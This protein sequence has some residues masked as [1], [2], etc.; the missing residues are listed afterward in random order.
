MR[1]FNIGS[2]YGRS[3]IDVITSLKRQMI[4][5]PAL[6]FVILLQLRPQH[7]HVHL[8]DVRSIRCDRS[9]QHHDQYQR[10]QGRPQ[11]QVR[12]HRRIF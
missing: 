7:G 2:G 12:S 4:T 6:L 1:I 8:R 5:A 3:L 11:L 10:R 9:I